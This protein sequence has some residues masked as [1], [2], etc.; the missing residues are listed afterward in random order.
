MSA[1]RLFLSL[2]GNDLVGSLAAEAAKAL[3]SD[4][5]G[6]GSVSRSIAR[7]CSRCPWRKMDKAQDSLERESIIPGRARIVVPGLHGNAERAPVVESNV[8]QLTG[9]YEARAN[10][11]TGRMLVLFEPELVDLPA[12]KRAM[13]NDGAVLVALARAERDLAVVGLAV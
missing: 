5:L 8:L 6:N 3:V 13:E 1:A 4:V 2:L 12:I 10:H 9:V 11:F 7:P